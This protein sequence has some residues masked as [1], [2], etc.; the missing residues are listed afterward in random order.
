M[1]T[2]KTNIEKSLKQ[3]MKE[4]KEWAK[5]KPVVSVENFQSILESFVNATGSA[6]LIETTT[7]FTKLMHT[8][9]AEIKNPIEQEVF[10]VIQNGEKAMAD[11]LTS[12]A[13][14]GLHDCL[15]HHVDQLLANPHSKVEWF[16][17]EVKNG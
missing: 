12:T 14:M 16:K 4:M 1:K 7:R 10:K 8:A 5:P 2:K 15:K 6:F 11:G 9:P 17:E 3:I 13:I